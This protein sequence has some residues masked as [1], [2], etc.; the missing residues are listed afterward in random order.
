MQLT[1]VTNDAGARDFLRVNVVIN[2]SNPNY[3]LPLE[4]D[5]REVFDPKKNK[6]FRHGEATRWILKDNSGKLVGRI[7][8]FVSKKYKNKG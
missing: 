2:E 1:E 6:S 3:I 8:A 4:K 5:V 7:A